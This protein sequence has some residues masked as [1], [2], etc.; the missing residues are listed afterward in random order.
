MDGPIYNAGAGAAQALQDILARKAL[1]KRQALLDSI[2]KQHADT[3][4]MEAEA[5]ADNLRAEGK[6][7]SEEADQRWLSQFGRDQ[8]LE[9]PDLERMQKEHPSLIKNVTPAPR[10]EQ[11]IP[12]D[13]G[14]DPLT[15]QMQ[16]D[17]SGQMQPIDVQRQDPAYAA[18]AGTPKDQQRQAAIQQLMKSL[19]EFQQKSAL[20]QALILRDADIDPADYAK[21]VPSKEEPGHAYSYDPDTGTWTEAPNVKVPPGQIRVGNRTSRKQG[22]TGSGGTWEQ[23]PQIFSDPKTGAPAAL[24]WTNKEGQTKI[25]DMRGQP[26]GPDFDPSKYIL[27]SQTSAPRTGTSSQEAIFDKTQLAQ[28]HKALQLVRNDPNTLS[29]KRKIEMANAF[30]AAA[31]LINQ[32]SQRMSPSAA[33][34]VAAVMKDYLAELQ[35]PAKKTQLANMTADQIAQAAQAAGSPLSP[36]EAALVRTVLGTLRVGK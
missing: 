31:S 18:F 25:T 3:Q 30:G 2:T 36:E 4:Q 24:H 9:G 22:G 20:E 10:M 28:Y 13:P 35:N 21:L 26:V 23:T 11:E 29:A 8:K 33:E 16:T 32:A 7:W 15:G 14:P 1:E 34:T 27:G 5:R 17:D 12:P 19:P 6:R